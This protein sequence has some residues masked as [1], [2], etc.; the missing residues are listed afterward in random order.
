[1]PRRW[2]AWRG[3]GGRGDGKG[4]FCWYPLGIEISKHALEMHPAP[5]S[6]SVPEQR[7]CTV[8]PREA[9]ASRHNRGDCR[10]HL[11]GIARHDRL[12]QLLSH[13]AADARGYEREEVRLGDILWRH[14]G[15]LRR[16]GCGLLHGLVRNL[17]HCGL[18]A[19]RMLLLPE[20][21][22]W[23]HSRRQRFQRSASLSPLPPLTPKKNHPPTQSCHDPPACDPSTNQTI[24]PPA[25][26]S[27]M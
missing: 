19:T 5:R 2:A 4:I 6:R 22:F 15:L 21:G 23:P 18:P 9:T 16:N 14:R 27:D 7:R 26:P 17:L 1:M 24:D 20:R 13:T 10:R 3:V 25:S 12:R 8:R 11:R